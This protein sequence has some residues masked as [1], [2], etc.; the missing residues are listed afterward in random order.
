MKAILP[1]DLLKKNQGSRAA[2]RQ[3]GQH[4]IILNKYLKVNRK[5]RSD[6][7]KSVFWVYYHLLEFAK[8]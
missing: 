1:T 2:A 8:V 6:S 7:I 3:T 4:N 5:S